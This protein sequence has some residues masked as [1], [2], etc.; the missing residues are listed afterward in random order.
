MSETPVNATPAKVETPAEMKQIV[1]KEVAAK[2]NKFSEKELS[3]MTGKDDLITQV[4]AKYG[5]GKPQVQHDV[6]ALLNG[7]SF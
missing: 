6:D 1:L 4:A 5:Q 2:W 7:R 3:A